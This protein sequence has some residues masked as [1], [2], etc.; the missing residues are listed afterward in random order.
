MLFLLF[1]VHLTL[2]ISPEA[3]GFSGSAQKQLKIN[4]GHLSLPE[5]AA[6]TPVSCLW[7]PGQS[8]FHEAVQGRR[9]LFFCSS[10][11]HG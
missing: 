7:G 1:I 2:D 11:G 5:W 8:R 9:T 4:T 6:A 10:P 3:K